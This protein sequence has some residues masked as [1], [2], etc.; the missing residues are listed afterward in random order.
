MPYNINKTGIFALALLAAI[1]AT[2]CD[3]NHVFTQTLSYPTPLFFQQAW[4]VFPAFFIAFLFMAINYLF[5]SHALRQKIDVAQSTT[6]GNW[7]NLSEDL[8]AF[9]CIYLLSGFGNFHPALLCF[10]FYFTFIIRQAFT[11]ERCWLCLLAILLAIGGMFFEGL[12]AEFGLV[13]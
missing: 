9:A 8:T 5:L 10:I 2:L 12:L 3:A 4:W 7:H 6:H 13:A 1:V 11:Y